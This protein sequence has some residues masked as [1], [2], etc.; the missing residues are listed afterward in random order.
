MFQ[1][2]VSLGQTSTMSNFD[3]AKTGQSDNLRW[4]FS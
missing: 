4:T 2:N 3:M 1:A